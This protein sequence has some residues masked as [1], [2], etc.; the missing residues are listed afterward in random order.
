MLWRDTGRA[1]VAPSPNLRSA[2]AALAYPGICLLEATNVSEGRGTESPFLT[3]G[4]PWLEPRPLLARLE[5]TG[6]RLEETAFTPRAGA[7]APE[8]KYDGV[9]CKGLRLRTDGSAPIRG[10]ELGLLLLRELRALHPEFRFLREGSALDRLLGTKSVREAL[11]RGETVGAI[12]RRE[13]AATEAFR[14]ER[15]RFLLY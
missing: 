3:I 14:R 6:F 7:A 1:W 9:L 4:A 10:Y 5:V 15:G 2:E 11:D 12:L 8:P 13:R